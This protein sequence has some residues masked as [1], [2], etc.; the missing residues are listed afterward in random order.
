MT[1]LENNL[2][3]MFAPGTLRIY[4]RGTD[5]T[6]IVGKM[7]IC[8]IVLIYLKLECLL[9][10]SETAH[11]LELVGSLNPTG[12]P[13]LL[14]ALNLCQTAA[15]SR[16]LRSNI[17]EPMTDVQSIRQRLDAVEELAS[18]LNDLYHPIKVDT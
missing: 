7:S 8:Y 11:R 17:L 9:S 13:S 2:N 4:Y 6:A 15:G 3:M 10:D 16:L 18:R 12:G 14:K 1:H 5:Q